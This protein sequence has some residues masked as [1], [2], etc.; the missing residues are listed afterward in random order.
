VTITVPA[1]AVRYVRLTVTGNTGWP[2][3]QIGEFEV[4]AF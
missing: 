3:A 4:Y 1:A 2:A